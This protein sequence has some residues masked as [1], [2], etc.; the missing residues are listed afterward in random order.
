M[1]VANG[2]YVG[3]ILGLQ[4][5]GILQ[6]R[7]GYRKTIL[8]ALVAMIGFIFIVGCCSNSAR[9]VTILK[10][11][12]QVFFATSL[13][14]LL[15]GEILCG[16]LLR[17]PRILLSMIDEKLGLPWGVFQT[18]TT[19]YAAGMNVRKAAEHVH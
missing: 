9:I 10:F 2:S 17:T 8:G 14:M 15:V 13:P 6:D 12:L 5:T 18:L 3:E 19:A 7:Y 11:V 4:L 1:N 16:R